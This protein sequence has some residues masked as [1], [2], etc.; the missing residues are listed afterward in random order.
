MSEPTAQNRLIGRLLLGAAALALPLTA[1]ITY[2]AQDAPAPPAPPE[3]PAAPA[4]PAV[5][6]TTK[7][8]IIDNPAG[9]TIDDKKLHTKVIE[10]DGKTIVLKTTKALSDAEADKHIEKAMG[11]MAEAHKMAG[12]DHS[13]MTWT[14]KDGEHKE[15]KIVMVE[16]VGDE[17]KDGDVKKTERREVRTFV[18]HGDGKHG[19]MTKMHHGAMVMTGCADGKPIEAKA[20]SKVNGEH[21]TSRV[22]ICSKGGDK[23]QA[24]AGLKKARDKVANDSSLSGEI[25]AEVLK[26]LDAEIAK[27]S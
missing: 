8:V 2:A 7:V 16:R 19:D 17:G 22:L 6:K 9:S 15:H 13:V 26:Q 3:A 27:L 14:G 10:K 11:S 4:A 23:A 5:K 18:M 25:K 20:E 12:K 1:S 24:L 21:K